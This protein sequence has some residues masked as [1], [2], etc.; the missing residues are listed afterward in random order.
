MCLVHTENKDLNGG[1]VF[2]NYS[3][4]SHVL[5]LPR[6]KTSGGG[7]AVVTLIKWTM[8]IYVHV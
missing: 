5:Y 8:S 3:T 1:S 4:V 6:T 2:L 7:G